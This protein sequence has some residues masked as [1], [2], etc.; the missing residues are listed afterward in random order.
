MRY[1]RWLL[2]PFAL[3]YGL[4]VVI[5]NGLYDLNIFKSTNF[6]FPIV[7]VGNLSA[8]GTGKTPHVEYLIKLLREEFNVAILSR[9]YKRKTNGYRLANEN[10]DVKEIGDEPRIYKVKYPEIP[11]AV[12]ENRS[13]AIPQ[14]L[15]DAPMTN[16]VLLDDAFQ[17]RQI[18]PGLS[19]LLTDYNNRFTNDY[20]LPVGYLREFTNARKR[21]EIM[22]VTKCPPS[23]TKLQKDEIIAELKPLD[24]QKV[25]FSYL[26]Y[27]TPYRLFYPNQKLI[28]DDHID[29]IL[30][31]GIANP[32]PLVAYLK[33]KVNSLILHDYSDHHLF[34]ERDMEQLKKTYDNYAPTN[35]IIVTTEKD[36]TRLELHAEWLHKSKLPIYCMPVEVDFNESDKRQFNKQITSYITSNLP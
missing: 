12:G 7:A 3:L 11:V 35:K 25:Y 24:N 31:T 30:L 34:S 16:V 33:D 23:L 8:G 14:L 21:A 19:V 13:L 36:A 2:L 18:N 22:V 5:R 32:K 10:S 28:I 29:V 6:D 9:G 20:L 17:H 4:I 15:T 26:K 1:L 27:A